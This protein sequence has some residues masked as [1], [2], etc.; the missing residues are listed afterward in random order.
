MAKTENRQALTTYHVHTVSG[1][2][3]NLAKGDSTTFT[4]PF[5]WLEDIT[6][7]EYNQTVEDFLE[8]YTWDDSWSVRERAIREGVFRY[9]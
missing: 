7:D 4:V 3:E 9:Q 6:V 5:E 8:S 1:P 2:H